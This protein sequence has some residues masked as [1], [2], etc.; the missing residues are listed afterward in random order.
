MGQIVASTN[1]ASIGRDHSN[2]EFFIKGS[3]QNDVSIFFKDQQGNLRV[4]VTGPLILNNNKVVGVVAI[5][6]NLDALRSQIETYDGVGQ[7]GEFNLV[8]RDDSGDAV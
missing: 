1:K 7:T 2:D 5:I 8:K 4:Y 6:S 3:K